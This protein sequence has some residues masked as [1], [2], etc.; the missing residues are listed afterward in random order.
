[1]VEK[2]GMPNVQ[3]SV[4]F[5]VQCRA[6][7]GFTLIELIVTIVLIGILGTGISSF[8]GNTTK[9][10]L[11]TADR[12]Q[13]STIAWLVSEN[14][15][16]HLRH[17]LPNSVRTSADGSCLEYIPIY[18][19]TDY[20]LAPVAVSASQ[21]EVVPFSNLAA[22]FNF[23]TQPLRVAIYPTTLA[24]LYNLSSSG[25][26][27]SAVS[28]L[29]A[30]TTANALNLQ[31]S[32]SHQFPS[33]SPSK[34]LFLVDQPVMFCFQSGMLYRYDSYGFNNSFTISGLNNQTV[35]GSKV[36]LGEFSYSSATL[37]RNAVINI[38]FAI[39]FADGSQQ[40]VN[41]E[42]QIRNVP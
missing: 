32:A 28:Q 42:V 33:D 19:G 11:D 21:F 40:A 12:S 7:Q 41:Q 8:I 29:S 38:S 6:Q 30:A 14:L 35:F 4:Q 26:I 17:A 22:G 5:R 24:G 27:S 16:R 3:V 23:A 15:S 31:M 34:R 25:V 9:G 10:M 39:S 18:A 36:Y 37:Q 2:F 13:V 1:M 20:L